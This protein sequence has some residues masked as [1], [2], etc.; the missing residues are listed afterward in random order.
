MPGLL[1]VRD[2]TSVA[3]FSGPWVYDGWLSL[4]MVNT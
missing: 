3:P 4:D 2:G 1:L